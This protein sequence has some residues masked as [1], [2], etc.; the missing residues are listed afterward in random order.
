MSA[1]RIEAK[2]VWHGRAVLGEGPLWLPA[3]QAVLFCDIKG[4]ALHAWFPADGSAHSWPAPAGLCWLVPRA[5]GEGFV[6]GLRGEVAHL[7]LDLTTGPRHLG[8]IATPDQ[9]RAG[10]RLNDGAADAAGRVWFG[11]MDDAEVEDIGRL[12]RLDPDGGLVVADSGYGVPNG[13][14]FAADGRTMFHADSARRLVYAYEIGADGAVLSRRE[15]LRFAE[16]DGYP[17][18]MAADAEGGLWVAHWEGGRV[19]RFDAEGRPEREIRLPVSRVTSV[20]FFGPELERIAITTAAI[21][22]DGEARAGSLFVAEPG[23]KGLSV[24]PTTVIARGR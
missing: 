23:V 4:G 19:T 22:R 15:H 24:H 17:D 11:S 1:G 10:M 16:A 3:Q 14:A 5:D 9:G 12:Y 6:A 2:A 13:P 8:T 18:G 21:G 20:A 7:A